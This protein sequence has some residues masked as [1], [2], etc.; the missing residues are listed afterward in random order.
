MHLV[1]R[2]GYQKVTIALDVAGPIEEYP[3]TSTG[4][5]P[6]QSTWQ[7]VQELTRKRAIGAPPGTTTKPVLRLL[8]I[9]AAKAKTGIRL[10]WIL[11]VQPKSS[12]HLLSFV[13]GTSLAISAA[14]KSG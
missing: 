12:K 2:R 1:P 10:L 13:K 4:M 7:S 5:Y 6:G 8:V 14:K 3:I 11:G 9:R